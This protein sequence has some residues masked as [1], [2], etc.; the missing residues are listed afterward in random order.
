MKIY[1]PNS[2]TNWNDIFYNFKHLIDKNKKIS[3]EKRLSRYKY[4]SKIL[5][6]NFKLKLTTLINNSSAIL[7]YILF[8]YYFFLKLGA[9]PE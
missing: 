7:K 4:Y 1:P 6:D 5:E 2:L 8:D 9:N 3:L